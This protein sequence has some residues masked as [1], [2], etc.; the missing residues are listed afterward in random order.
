MS[1][2]R[3]F[4][5]YTLG[6]LGLFV[7][8]AALIWSGFGLAGT[9]INGMPLLLLSLIGSS[10]LALVLL[11]AQRDRFGQALAEQRAAKASELAARQARL[12]SD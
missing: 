1:L 7:V 3:A 11:R 8:V 2:R 10:V 4:L 9:S 6:R 12:D 5:V